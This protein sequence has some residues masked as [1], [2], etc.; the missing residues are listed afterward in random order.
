MLKSFLSLFLQ[1]NC[2]LCDRSTEEEICQDCL[3]Q[4]KSQQIKNTAQFW[5]GELPLF[6]WGNYEGKLKQAIA[7][8]KYNRHPELGE[9]MGQWLGEAWL[10]S[11]L[12]KKQK[13]SVIPIPMHQQKLKERGFNQ[14]ELMAKGF[15]K[16]TGYNLQ[17]HGL[18]R[19]RETQ[20]MYSL[21][22]KEREENVKNA[23]NIG[24]LNQTNTP[25]LLIDDIYTT[26]TTAKEVAKCLNS[27]HV[28]VVGIATLS[29]V[30][31]V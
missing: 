12:E 7:A 26:G 2:P 17:S 24:K 1:Q 5:Y 28:N 18:I 15:C 20:A 4:L 3:R 11:S 22:P 19:I 25:V 31:Q 14:A 16:T 23:F 6:V 8:L 27:H 30:R 9:V 13:F 21:K 29:T 10:K